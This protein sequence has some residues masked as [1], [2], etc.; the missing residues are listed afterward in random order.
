MKILLVSH[1][2]LPK[3]MGGTEVCV[4]EAAKELQAKGHTVNIICTDPLSVEEPYSVTR[5]VYHGISVH[6]IHKNVM[7]LEKYIDTYN[8]K[9]I[10]PVFSSLLEQLKPDTVHFHH[11]MHL[12]LDCFE[13]VKA[14]SIPQILTLHDFWFQ[15]PLFDR[16]FKD[17]TLYKDYS[18]ENEV[19][20]L[21]NMLNAGS[22]EYTPPDP[23]FFM[24]SKNKGKYIVN[25]VKKIRSRIKAAVIEN[26]RIYKYST[27]VEARNRAMRKALATVDVVVFPTLFLFQELV[28]WKFS[29]KKILF[30]PDPINTSHFKKHTIKP[31]PKLRFAFIGSIIPSKGVDVLIKAWKELLPKKAELHIYGNLETDPKYGAK[32]RKLS[33]GCRSIHFKGTFPANEVAQIYETFDIVVIPSRWFENVPL[34][35]RNA[36]IAKQPVIATDLGSLT[37]TITHDKTGYLFENENSSDLAEKMKEFIDNPQLIK[38]MRNNFPEMESVEEQMEEMVALYKNLRK[39]KN[40]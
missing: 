35:L 4:F 11:I 3:Y 12:S 1:T 30:R 28:G 31:S 8:D 36:F 16:V 34:V 29:A 10:N 17:G 13:I 39:E 40:G 24:K 19:K 5:S 6:T 2:F 27:L 32:I 21:V 22:V 25:V 33:E 14:K 15:T 38:D 18:F 20:I 23:K 9:K 7:D 37:E 26:H